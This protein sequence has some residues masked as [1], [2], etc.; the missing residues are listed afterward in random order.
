MI[1]EKKFKFYVT[2]RVHAKIYLMKSNDG[3]CRVILSSANFSANAWQ[4]RQKENFV[5]MDEPEAYED[6]LNVFEELRKNSSE[7]IG[8]DARPLKED[9]TNLEDLPAMKEIV[10]VKKVFKVVHELPPEFKDEAAYLF[11]QRATAENFRKIFKEVGIHSN[12]EGKTLINAEK[13]IAMKKVIKT[14]QEKSLAIQNEKRDTAPEFILNFDTR[15]V[16]LNDELWNLNPP[17]EEVRNDIKNLIDYV[18]GADI[19]TGNSADLKIYYWKIIL[20]MF[21]SPFFARLRYFYNNILPANST[22]KTFPMYMILR[23]GK[24]GGK[25]SIVA[26]GQKLMFDRL[27]PTISAK[28]TAPS[29]IESFKLTIK[30]CPI[31]IDDVTNSLI[32]GKILDHGTFIFTSNDADQIKQEISKRVVVFTIKNQLDEDIATK[33]DSALKKLQNEMHNALYRA[34]L[35]KIF[36]AVEELLEEIIGG[37]QTDWQPDI[38]K[39]SSETLTKIFQE[40]GFDVPPELKIFSWEDYLGEKMKSEQAVGTIEKLFEFF[41]QIFSSDARKNR[42][43]I[44]LSTL[45]QKARQKVSDILESELPP[46]TEK[47]IV[48]NIVTMKLSEIKKFARVSLTD[49][50]NFL[51]KFFSLFSRN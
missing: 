51:Q 11:A 20:Y 24:N 30:G 49:D 23:G 16:S 28:D 31:L 18:N 2:Y 1:K 34:Y 42:L 38:F 32:N 35:K 25:F 10:N 21:A 27:L 43:M 14:A 7:E 9:G 50:K 8:V 6:Y 48:G 17:A 41:P 44:D 12:A 13:I 46:S 4:M 39:I 47:N 36:P 5:V 40:H 37:G 19:F 22:G 15:T 26:T 29:K 45:D 33:R 3:R